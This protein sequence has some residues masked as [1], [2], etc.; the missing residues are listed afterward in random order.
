MVLKVP[1]RVAVACVTFETAK[2]TRP[3]LSIEGIERA[4]LFHFDRPDPK[5]TWFIYREFYEEVVRQLR[6]TR[7]SLEI[8]EENIPVYE[9]KE[10]LAAL[11]RILRE[12]TGAGNHVYVNLSAGTAEYTAAAT[13]ASMMVPS[14]AVPF[15]VATKAY[16]VPDEKLKE[17]YYEDGRPVGMARE[18]YPPEELPTFHVERPPEDLVRGLMVLRTR[19]DQARKVTYAAMIESLRTEGCWGCG[20]H[21]GSKDKAQADKMY[22]RR[23]F[24]DGWE[25]RGWVGRDERDRIQLTPDGRTVTEV[26]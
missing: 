15:T 3:I 19:L 22:Y 11:V 5:K 16:Q 13:V 1:K 14:G 21:E 18:V 24:L 9:F 10:V 2:I 8:V 4:Y 12:E 26:F 7:P 25:A 17:I 23:H 20:E 6:E